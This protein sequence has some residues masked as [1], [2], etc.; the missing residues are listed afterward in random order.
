[1]QSMT[2]YVCAYIFF[3][4]LW[5]LTM[6]IASLVSSYSS[7][8][9]FKLNRVLWWHWWPFKN[10][11]NGAVS[12]RNEHYSNLIPLSSF[13]ALLLSTSCLA[14]IQTYHCA[15][16]LAGAYLSIPYWTMSFRNVCEHKHALPYDLYQ[17]NIVHSLV[18]V[19]SFCVSFGFRAERNKHS[20]SCH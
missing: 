10:L 12:L 18:W 3:C 15:A 1:M 6:N 13:I 20:N 5:A 11:A 2:A 4:I 16:L 19:F 9:S 17:H 14:H 8:S 7:C